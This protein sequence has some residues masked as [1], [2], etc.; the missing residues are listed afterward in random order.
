MANEK[1]RGLD[2]IPDVDPQAELWRRV[3]EA[4]DAQLSEIRTNGISLLLPSALL[5]QAN[6]TPADVQGFIRTQ[7]EEVGLEDVLIRV[8]VLPERTGDDEQDAFTLLTADEAEA[9]KAPTKEAK[10]LSDTSPGIQPVQRREQTSE[11][12]T[13]MPTTPTG[14]TQ[15]VQRA[16]TVQEA[17]SLTGAAAAAKDLVRKYM[18]R[19]K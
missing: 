17:E 7:L 4:I 5:R 3:N 19:P 11:Q 13:T 1:V 2:V 16:G 14:G 8:G 6:K 15:S 9:A 18:R 10:A 12:A